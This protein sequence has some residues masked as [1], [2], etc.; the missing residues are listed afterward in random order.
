MK[1]LKVGSVVWPRNKIRCSCMAWLLG[2]ALAL[3]SNLAAAQPAP[4]GNSVLL[5]ASTDGGGM[6]TT[7]ANAQ[8]LTVVSATAVQWAA[9]TTA[10]FATFRA[11]ILGDATCSTLSAVAA[12]EANA[13]VWA[14]AID[15]P[16][17]VIGTDEQFHSASGGQQLASSGISFV[18][19]GAP[20]K[21][22]AYISLSCYYDSTPQN[23]PV[24]LLAPF[25]TFT[26]GGT[27]CYNDAHVVAIHPALA[28][29][30][31][32]TLSNWSCS[33]HE[34]FN[35]FPTAT[36][37]PLAIAE[38]VTGPGQMNFADGTTGIPYILA[39]GGG[40]VPINCGNGVLESPEECDDGNTTS[41][42]GCS[43]FCT[44]EEPVVLVPTLSSWMMALLAVVLAGAGIL[45]MRSY[46]QRVR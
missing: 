43:S 40:V 19:S 22:G 24:P 34:F 30:T 8:G 28:S 3:L 41:G 9:R 36:F 25:G 26:V 17:L 45:M 18:T 37:L 38:N 7:L 2:G 31:D 23:T 32:A 33:T 29:S 35:S 5:L 12:A 44:I 4:D 14:A 1:N 15:G 46:K 39:S 21:T 13:P 16:I 27:N 10:D 20:G 6:Y 11:L 42:D